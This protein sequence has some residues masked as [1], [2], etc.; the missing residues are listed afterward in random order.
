MEERRDKAYPRRNRVQQG[1]KNIFPYKKYLNCSISRRA[2]VEKCANRT[3][4]KLKK[5]T[6]FKGNKFHF[7][8]DSARNT[9]K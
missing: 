6:H 4:N 2:Y 3:D 5:K 9:V 7:E 8:A 1:G